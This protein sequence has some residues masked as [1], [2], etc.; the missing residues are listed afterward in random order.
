MFWSVFASAMLFLVPY[1]PLP[2]YSLSLSLVIAF[3]KCY[4]VG[5]VGWHFA[6]PEHGQDLEDVTSLWSTL[7]ASMLSSEV[8]CG[9]TTR[10]SV[11]T[12]ALVF[13]QTLST[14]KASYIEWFRRSHSKGEL[15]QSTFF[16][17]DPIMRTSLQYLVN[18]IQ[19]EFL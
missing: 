10:N 19:Q 14:L 5:T 2:L 8:T 4:Y 13:H 9:R 11:L 3:T 15:E 6:L 7:F 18:F 17:Q 16:F 12:E 1:Y